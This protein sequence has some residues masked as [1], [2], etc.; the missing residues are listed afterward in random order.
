MSNLNEDE[1]RVGRH[2]DENVF[3]YE[4]SRPE[5]CPVEFAITARQPGFDRTNGSDA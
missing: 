5:L 1:A 4:N 3:E 2:Y